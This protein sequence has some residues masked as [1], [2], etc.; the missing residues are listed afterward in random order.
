MADNQDQIKEIITQ[1]QRTIENVQALLS[2]L[3]A[4]L[5]SLGILPPQ[6][7]KY[8]TNPLAPH[9]VNVLKHIP[10]I[11]T[12]LLEHIL[13]T[14]DTVLRGHKPNATHLVKQY[15]CPDSFV[16]ALPVSGDL[17][18]KGYETILTGK[19]SPEG[20]KLLESITKDYPIDR[21]W[22]AVFGGTIST[23][24]TNS[25]QKDR[26]PAVRSL[27]WEDCVRDIVS[28]PAKVANAIGSHGDGRKLDIPTLLENGLFLNEVCTRVEVLV[29]RFTKQPVRGEVDCF[30]I[31]SRSLKK[32][33]LFA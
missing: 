2:L 25:A 5:D 28:I 20:I 16:N 23:L 9:S 12:A 6:F 27:M 17:A 14:W 11:Q 33:V 7:R 32:R 29:E 3:T 18:L 19:L 24:R 15:F 13:P 26:D 30:C 4:P 8:N 10:P 22:T 1:L 21:L 31:A